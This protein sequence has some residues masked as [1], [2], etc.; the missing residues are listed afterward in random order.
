MKK[1]NEK[2][3]TCQNVVVTDQPLQPA[4]TKR[5]IFEINIV[6]SVC[7]YR[8][9]QT[10]QAYLIQLVTQYTWNSRTLNITPMKVQSE[11]HAKKNSTKNSWSAPEQEKIYNT[12]PCLLSHTQPCAPC[13]SQGIQ[14]EVLLPGVNLLSLQ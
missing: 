10:A 4:D 9:Q 5:S 8:L 3:I 6:S 11:A 13:D 1:K 2:Q 7:M 14:S 12:Y